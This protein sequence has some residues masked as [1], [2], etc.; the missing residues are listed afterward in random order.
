M[1]QKHLN[2]GVRQQKSH[3]WYDYEWK[4]YFP[5]SKFLMIE[6]R[7]WLLPGPDPV[8][9]KNIQFLSPDS[10]ALK[11]YTKDRPEKI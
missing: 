8:T 6:P 4:V 1:V 2:S 7:L 3:K 5:N 11:A 10:S 9:N